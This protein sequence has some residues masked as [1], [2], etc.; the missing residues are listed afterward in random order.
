MSTSTGVAPT[1]AIASTVAMN[2]FA[3]VMTSSPGPTPN[4]RSASSMAARPVPTEIAWRVPMSAA[5]SASNCSTAGPENE[6]AP[7]EDAADRGFDL[8]RQ[9]AVLRFQVDERHVHGRNH[10]FNPRPR[11]TT[12]RRMLHQSTTGR[13][14]VYPCS[15]GG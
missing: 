4:A 3:A 10:F 14:F 1:A 7:L 11:Y 12:G 6:V 2:V 9:R 13:I 5:Y 15:C 8:R